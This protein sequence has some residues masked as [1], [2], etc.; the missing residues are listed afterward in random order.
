MERTRLRRPSPDEFAEFYRSYV[1]RV[2]DGDVVAVLRDQ[3]HATVDMLRGVSEERA[4]HR[5]AP[6]KW[7]VADVVGHVTDT[8]RIFAYRAMR[9]ARG[10]ATP[11]PGVDQDDL[12]VHGPFVGRPFQNIVDELEQQRAAN[13]ALF[14][15]FDEDVLD[16]RGTASDCPVTVRAQLYILA[17]HEA[18]HVAVLR[19]RYLT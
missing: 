18:H 15:T 2:P 8:E 7:T 9:I 14:S 11:L 12:M 3:G 17:G 16:R 19:G 1:D 6:G 4:S 13:V 10:D 5:Y